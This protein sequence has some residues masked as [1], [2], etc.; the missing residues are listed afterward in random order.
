[1][2]NSLTKP[3]DQGEVPLVQVT[4]H[5]G[6]GRRRTH[7]SNINFNIRW[8]ATNTAQHGVQAAAVLHG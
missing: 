3:V 7:S 1:M 5:L 8:A 6:R 2:D 4:E